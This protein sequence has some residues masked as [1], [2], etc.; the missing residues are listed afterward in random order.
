MKSSHCPKYEQKKLK[1]SALKCSGQN[2][3][4]FLFI[5]WAMGQLHIFIL[6][7]SDLQWKLLPSLPHS[8]PREYRHFTVETGKTTTT[9]LEKVKGR[10]NTSMAMFAC[11]SIICRNDE[12][13]WTMSWVGCLLK[14]F[15]T[16]YLISIKQPYPSQIFCCSPS[17]NFHVSGSS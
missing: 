16:F 8:R 2:F 13:S 3:S 11:E 12:L 4:N 6:K 9:L 15:R 7:F 1:N 10:T 5:F 17:L 14:K